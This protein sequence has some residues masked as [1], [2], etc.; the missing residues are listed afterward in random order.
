MFNGNDAFGEASIFNG[1]DAFGEASIRCLLQRLSRRSQP[2]HL[3]S[4]VLQSRPSMTLRFKQDAAA[5]VRLGAFVDNPPSHA[6]TAL[7][8]G[9]IRLAMTAG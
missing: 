7:A 4:C 9:R 6:G 8:D 3:P 1:N 5:H 2:C